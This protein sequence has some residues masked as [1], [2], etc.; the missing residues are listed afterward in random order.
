MLSPD[1][2]QVSKY[3]DWWLPVKAGQDGAFWMAVDHVILKEFF[4]DR[5][6]PYFI[7]YLKR[8]TDTP[9]LVTLTPGPNGYTPGRLL[10]GRRHQP[11]RDV[12]NGEWK[13]LVWDVSPAT[14][15]APGHD[16]LQMG[17]EKGKWNLEF[18]DGLDDSAID[19]MLSL[20]EDR[21]DVLEVRVTEEGG[22]TSPLRG[23]PV[24][25]VETDVGRVA[26]TTVLD[27]LMAKFGV[28]RG[29]PGDYPQGYDDDV[30]YTPA[31]Q[32]K[33]TGIDRETVIR[34]AREFAGN[35]ERTEGKSMVIIGTGVN[36]WYHSN[37]MY[38]SAI[39][40]LMLCGCEGRNG[41]GMNHYVGQEKVAP[42]APWL[43]IAFATDWQKPSRLQNTPSS[44]T[45]T[46]TSGDTSPSSPGTTRSCRATSTLTATPWISR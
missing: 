39:T 24:K 35:A 18:K 27:L 2:S 42:F 36:Q 8:Y 1:F 33:L 43:T 13:F 34:F 5:Q 3:A 26:V 16:G 23:V 29:L 21:D 11:I 6:V 22:A 10:P 15:A 28:S 30:P 38:R 17:H 45:S 4:V 32:E 37:L 46:P 25:Y 7:D 40:A 12:E 20:L 19:P 41:G 31:W 44:S 14:P 9:F